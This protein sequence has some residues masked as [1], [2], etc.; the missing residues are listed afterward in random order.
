[1]F[2]LIKKAKSKIALENKQL[3]SYNCVSLS[4]YSC[5]TDENKK[6]PFCIYDKE[7]YN[8][9]YPKY[10]TSIRKANFLISKAFIND[11]E[12][13]ILMILNFLIYA[14]SKQIF[15]YLLLKK[16]HVTKEC[17]SKKL[18]KL[19]EKS[20]VR[21]LEFKTIESTS[22]FKVY[23]LGK[24]GI[25]FLKN[26]RNFVRTPVKLPTYKMKKILAAS[27]LC[28][29]IAAENEVIFRISDALKLFIDKNNNNFIA[30]RPSAL[31]SS[32]NECAMIEAVRRNSNWENELSEKLERY[33]FFITNNNCFC[34]YLGKNP[35][36]ILLCEDFE[37]INQVR[38]I[39]PDKFLADINVLFTYDRAFHEHNNCKFFTA[40]QYI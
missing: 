30:L 37:H 32:E 38:K 17:V 34:S 26:N 29:Y 23:L 19:K 7:I 5:L 21:Q 31:I 3:F 35:H 2:T 16:Y 25:R 14:T 8:E 15:D 27:Q 24:Y 20:F 1:M 4:E 40:K 9:L 39:V 12:Q 22:S 33:Y 13:E 10:P 36:L 18:V 28:L 11:I 6:S